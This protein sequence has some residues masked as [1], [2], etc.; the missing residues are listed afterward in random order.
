VL[1]AVLT[2]VA[3]VFTVMLGIVHVAIPRLVGFRSAL[4]IDSDRS[5][6]LGRRSPA[7]LGFGSRTYAVRPSDLLGITWVMSNAA[8]FVLVSIGVLDLAWAAGWRGIPIV[9]GGIWVAL[10]W[11]LRALGQLALGHRSG[12]LAALAWFAAL[13]ACHLALAVSSA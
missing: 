7:S 6:E 2:T 10:W 5:D 8:S 13:A 1:L 4:G 12:D 9:A 3:G 11:T